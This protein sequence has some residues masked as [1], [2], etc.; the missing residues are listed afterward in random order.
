MSDDVTGSDDDAFVSRQAAA[1]ERW[2]NTVR[3]LRPRQLYGRVWFHAYHP[4]ALQRSAPTPR[5]TSG[6]WARSIPR[7]AQLVAPER[8]EL[9]SETRDI[10]SPS[11]WNAADVPRLW[12]YH[13][14]YFDDLNAH[15]AHE[16]AAWHEALIERWIAENRPGRGTGW[17]PYPASLRIVNWIKWAMSGGQLTPAALQSLATQARWLDK[18]LEWHL[19]GN[20]L[21]V[22]AKAM[23]IAGCFFAGA[24][25]DRWRQRGAEILGAQL[26]EQVLADGG[27]FER[28]PMYHALVLEDVLDLLN[29]AQCWPERLPSELVERLRAVAPAMLRWLGCLSHPDGDI[30][31]FNDSA[32]GVAP[33]RDELAAY[34]ARLGLAAAEPPRGVQHLAASGFARVERGPFVLHCDIGDIGPDYLPGHAHASSLCFELSAFGQ[35]WLVNSGCSTYARGAER[36]RQRGTA[37]HNTVVVNGRDSSEVWSSFRV[38]RRAHVRDACVLEQGERVSVE[39]SHDGYKRKPGVVHRR[40]FIADAGG[41]EIEDRLEGTFERAVGYLHLHPDVDAHLD[42][43]TQAVLSR[44]GERLRLRVVGAQLELAET[45][46][47]PSFNSSVP[48]RVLRLCFEGE[49]A[50]ARIE[51]T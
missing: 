49:V 36:L 42:G 29:A 17:E 47:H 19:L 2:W 28:S 21:L 37:A 48:S 15:G 32:L 10:S 41:V 40:R 38:A 46:W 33:S 44:G 4:R 13:L 8:I 35:R 1:L 50:R 18:R 16:R 27:H 26:A 31:L 51:R 23:A 30:A 14:H 45:T 7:P 5:F 22:N 34:A 12:L 39:A 20:H 3:W 25:A 11:I 24:E 43:G 6:S 9:L